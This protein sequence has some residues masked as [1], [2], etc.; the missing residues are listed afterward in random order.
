MT[1]LTNPTINTPTSAAYNELI[2]RIADA[3]TLASSAAVLGWDQQVM[4]P[5]GGLEYR[6]RQLAQLAKLSHELATDP[7]L[8]DLL[9]ECEADDD[10]TADPASVTAVNIREIRHDYDR[11]TKLPAKL[12]EEEARLA[13]MGEYIWAEARKESNFSRFRPILA[14]VIDLLRRKAECYGWA[15]GGEP[16]DALAEDYEP[17]CTAANVEKVFV[18]LRQ[19]LK[20]L[21]DDLMRNG[22]APSNRFNEIALPIEKQEQ[23]VRMVATGIGFD[24][25]RGR[26]DRST[27]PFCSGSHPGDVRLTTRFRETDLNDALGSTMH[28]CGHGIYEQG[29]PPVYAGLPMGTSVSLGI[30]ESQS[31]MWENQVGRSRAFWEWCFPRLRETFGSGVDGLTLEDVYGGANIVRP[32]FIR[33]EADEATYNMHIM[34]RFELERAILKGDLAVDDIPAA[35]NARYK[36]YL[37]LDVPNDAKGCLQDI[38]WSM[39]AMGYFPTYTLGNLYAAQFFEKAR[40]D[41][42]DLE[43]QFRR[44]EFAGLK[45]WLNEHIHR[46]GRRYTPGELC[47]VVTGKPLSADP[48]LRHLEGKLRPIYGL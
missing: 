26:L 10:L 33:V 48:L 9:A 22:K 1:T 8:A 30:H 31:R 15:E 37:G 16:W 5:P 20:A 34:V 40:A 32:D 11:K 45:T 25:E 23:F 14:Q 42:P 12:V 28:E 2:E 7:R 38:H 46:H 19:R 21:L 29:L 27:H 13:S 47:E 6:S 35:W 18:P 44:G 24:F 39:T 4:M 43:D 3:A 41:M 17:G 36:E